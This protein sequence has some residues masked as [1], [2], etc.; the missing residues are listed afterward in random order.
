MQQ[1]LFENILPKTLKLRPTEATIKAEDIT[2]S[3]LID[4][5]EDIL[6]KYSAVNR[7]EFAL[8]GRYYVIAKLKEQK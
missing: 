4:E 6:S 5:A 1:S 2:A 8:D 3:N 7:V